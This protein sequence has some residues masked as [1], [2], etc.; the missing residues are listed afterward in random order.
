M[1]IYTLLVIEEGLVCPGQAR[2]V[3]VHAFDSIA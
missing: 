1:G 2:V 3:N